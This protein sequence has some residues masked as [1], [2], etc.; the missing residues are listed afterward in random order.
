LVDFH[1]VFFFPLDFVELSEK[2]Q[3]RGE[4][5]DLSTDST[6][7]EYYLVLLHDVLA[8]SNSSN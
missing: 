2:V 3:S 1:G 7:G 5:H 6:A 4:T 8:G